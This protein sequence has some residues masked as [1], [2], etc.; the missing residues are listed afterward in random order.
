[1][2]TLGW[3][4]P[5]RLHCLAGLHDWRRALD[6][7]GTLLGRSDLWCSCVGKNPHRLHIQTKCHHLNEVGH[8]ALK[9]GPS[10]LPQ[11][12]ALGLMECQH[13]RA[14]SD[15]AKGQRSRE[16]EAIHWE[17]K[18]SWSDKVEMVM[19]SYGSPRLDPC[20]RCPLMSRLQFS[21]GPR[22]I[23]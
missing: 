11:R 10:A 14:E 17:T 7:C 19:R 5:L 22:M 1:M 15:S 8:S 16:N 20:L 6:L 9:V 23:Y 21:L 12:G 13:A 4:S 2:S 18:A 3:H